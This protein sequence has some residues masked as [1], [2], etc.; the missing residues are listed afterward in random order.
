M[1]PLNLALF[2]RDGEIKTLSESTPNAVRKDGDD[3]H[4]LDYHQYVHN[5]PKSLDVVIH[6]RKLFSVNR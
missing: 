5:E 1:E 2:D 6:C 3:F 4:R